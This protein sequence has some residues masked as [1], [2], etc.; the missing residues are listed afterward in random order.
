MTMELSQPFDKFIHLLM[1]GWL[2]GALILLYG[3]M[4]HLLLNGSVIHRPPLSIKEK[5]RPIRLSLGMKV[6]LTRMG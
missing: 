1:S 2:Y 5:S 3:V 4:T 6:L